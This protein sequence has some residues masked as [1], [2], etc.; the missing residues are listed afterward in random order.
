MATQ[1]L[2][3]K[4]TTPGAEVPAPSPAIVPPTDVTAAAVA[5]ACQ[6]RLS[7]LATMGPILFRVGSAELEAGGLAAIEDVAGAA[8]SCPELSIE[9]TGHAS[10]EGGEDRNWRL[11]IERARSVLAYLVK[12]GVEEKRLEAVGY[13]AARPVAP[14]DSTANMAR[15]RRIEFVVRRR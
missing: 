6:D 5:S 10:S 11:S 13:G 8:K 12:A 4:P 7:T 3:A 14:N 15:N 9:I 2:P 1:S